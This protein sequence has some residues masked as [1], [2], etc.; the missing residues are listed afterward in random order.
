MPVITRSR[1]LFWAGRALAA[2]GHAAAARA[3][4]EQAATLANTFYGQMA[5]AWLGGNTMN[6]LLVPEQAGRQI[7]AYLLRQSEPTPSVADSVRFDTTD[8]A[9]AAEILVAWG[10][11]G[12]R[13]TSSWRWMRSPPVPSTMCWPPAWPRGWAYPMPP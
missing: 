9:R 1:G 11:G 2:E 5:I 7:R 12:M 3:Q 4:W 13:V 8:L 10:T 6:P